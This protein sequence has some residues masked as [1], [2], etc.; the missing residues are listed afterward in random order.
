MLQQYICWRAMC[1]TAYAYFLIDGMPPNQ[2]AL[3][4]LRVKASGE[5]SK[6]RTGRNDR[7][8]I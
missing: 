8:K 5:G 2:H 1:T 6:G 3:V 7:T 4:E